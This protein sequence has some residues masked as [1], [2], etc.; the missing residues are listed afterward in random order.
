[1]S[2][3]ATVLRDFLAEIDA[4]IFKTKEALKELK[5]H[6]ISVQRH[7]ASVATYPVLTLP[8]EITQEIFK[9]CL[10]FAEHSSLALGELELC[11]PMV[12]LRICRQ[13][14]DIAL[15][16]PELWSTL[17]LTF[18]TITPGVVVP[19]PGAIEAYIDQWFGRAA[20]RPVS[21]AM[22]FH[23]KDEDPL[24]ECIFSI[25]RMRRLINRYSSKLQYLELDLCQDD[26]R[27]LDLDTMEF[28]TL[29]KATFNEH[30]NAPESDPHDPADVFDN[31]PQ[32]F[33]VCLTGHA[34]SSY[35]GLPWLQLTTFEGDVY[36][37][38]LFKL[39]PNL[40][41]VICSFD[42][43]HTVPPIS[44]SRLQ[45]LTLICNVAGEETQDILKC[46]TL[47]ALQCLRISE[48]Y[49]TTY[50]SLRS[51]LL[52]STPPLTTLSIRADNDGFADCQECLS[53]VAATLEDL[54]LQHP[55]PRVQRSIL[56]LHNT[57]SWLR[58]EHCRISPPLPKLR[59]LSFLD[60]PGTEYHLL[61]HFIHARSTDSQ[62]TKLHSVRVVWGYGTSF[63][64]MRKESNFVRAVARFADAGT[65]IHIGT[66]DGNYLDF[67]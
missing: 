19:K 14:R 41:E 18:D 38:E 8:V 51:F 42:S 10:P 21:L 9:Q 1:M 34:S 66:E 31:A 16:T 52:R 48:M 2:L 67:Q 37:L 45:S 40:T 28:P 27:E 62:L 24:A 33:S 46:L 20:L 55:S 11:A 13:W 3:T 50:S 7:L 25:G 57:L 44:H 35:Y 60:S 23:R 59:N 6:R 26:V 5:K 12:L 49:D 22:G 61:E 15:S 53:S 4:Q 64:C 30:V 29:Q 39:A 32:L 17:S 56:Y 58:M 47:P 36:N 54:E 43:R 63:L 65:H